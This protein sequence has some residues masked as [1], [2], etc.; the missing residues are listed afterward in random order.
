MYEKTAILL[1]LLPNIVNSQVYE[2]TFSYDAS[3]EFKTKGT[4]EIIDDT[5]IHIKV[6]ERNPLIKVLMLNYSLMKME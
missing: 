4:L 6:F 5:K 3:L 1:I 2:L